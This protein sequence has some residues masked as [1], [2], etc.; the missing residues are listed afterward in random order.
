MNG[1]EIIEPFQS[2]V[3]PGRPT[4]RYSQQLTGIAD[5]MVA[6]AP[7]FEEIAE[8]FAR[9]SEGAIFVAHNVSFDYQFLQHEYARLEQRFV[10]P[11]ICAKAGMMKYYPD[12]SSFG[13]GSLTEKY[14]I[15]NT[16]HHRALNDASVAAQL[17][18]LINQK[19]KEL[20]R[21]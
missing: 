7:R 4:P 20:A 17:L 11:H 1:S 5:A 6:E 10:R 13:L 21:A 15:S 3:N 19:R 8:S 9:V 12:N 16:Q 14:S 18:L 2:L